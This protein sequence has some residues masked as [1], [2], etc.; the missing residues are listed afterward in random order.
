MHVIIETGLMEKVCRGDLS[1][2]DNQQEGKAQVFV[3]SLFLIWFFLV[4]LVH[5]KRER[6]GGGVGES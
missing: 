4:T 2:L 3:L 5:M 1:D 6:G